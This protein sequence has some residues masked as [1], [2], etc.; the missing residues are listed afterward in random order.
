VDLEAN[1]PELADKPIYGR[2]RSVQDPRGC[3]TQIFCPDAGHDTTFK[4]E[5]E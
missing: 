3:S 4:W 1:D 2:V 5:P